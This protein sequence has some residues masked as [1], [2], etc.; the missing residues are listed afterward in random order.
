ML[1]VRFAHCFLRTTAE[2][3]ETVFEDGRVC[4]A[5][6]LDGT[7]QRL[8]SYDLGYFGDT[9]RMH[10]HHEAA[11]TLIAE[12]RGQPYSPTL[13]NVAVPGT[14]ADDQRAEEE[15]I[16]FSFQRW[17]RAGMWDPRLAAIPA[18]DRVATRVRFVAQAA[19]WY[20]DRDDVVEMRFVDAGEIGR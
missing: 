19:A 5:V 6:F 20:A 18:V 8:H 16:V 17:I 10:L 4:P 1:V 13:R 15:S 9:R 14:A 11:H 12:A 7:E 3:C 2:G